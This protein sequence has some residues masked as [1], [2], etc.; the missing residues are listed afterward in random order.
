VLEDVRQFLLALSAVMRREDQCLLRPPRLQ[1]VIV[2]RSAG[3]R[4]S[5]LAVSLAL[6]NLQTHASYPEKVGDE[7][8]VRGEAAVAAALVCL[9][10]QCSPGDNIFVATPHRIQRQAVKAAIA[11]M[12]PSGEALVAATENMQ[13]SS[14]IPADPPPKVVVDTVE[15]L[16]GTTIS[17][18]GSRNTDANIRQAPRQPS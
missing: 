13:I 17:G 5:P 14:N 3:I 16:Q 4:L 1:T 18:T 8:H 11:S 2:D 6:I 12:R 15:R 7:V 9:I 10:R